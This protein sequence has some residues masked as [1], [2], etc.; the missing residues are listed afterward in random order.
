MQ[1]KRASMQALT[2]LIK[3]ELWASVR[4]HVRGLV[5]CR[6]Y[7]AMHALANNAKHKLKLCNQMLVDR[8][9]CCASIERAGVL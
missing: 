2:M 4:A 6:G 8:F 1:N 9:G 7:L 5:E 3:R